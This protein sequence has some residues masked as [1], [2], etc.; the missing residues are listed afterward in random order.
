ML[1]R[2]EVKREIA[3]LRALVLGLAREGTALARF[4]AERR[5]RVT[6][7]D[8]K[9]AADLADRISALAGL[10]V[11]F[12]LGGHPETLLDETDIVFVSPGVPLEIPFLVE[13]R[14]RGVPLSSE[15]RL[16]TRLCPAIVVGVTGSS[17]KSTTTVLAGEMIRAAGWRTWIGGNIG[18]PLIGFLDEIGPEDAV[19]MELSSFQ[20]DLFGPWPARMHVG[21]R[22]GVLFDPDGWSPPVAAVLNVTPNHL[23][24]HPTMEDYVA[25]KRHILVHQ[26]PSD[27][28]VLNFD[29]P[30]TREMGSRATGAGQRV[31]WFSLDREVEE[32]ALLRDGQ[33][34]L[35]LAGIDVTV[36]R[37]DDLKLLGRHNLANALAACALAAGANIVQPRIT[38][39]VDLAQRGW[40]QGLTSFSGVEHRLELVRELNGVCW[41]NDSIATTPERTVAALRS[42]EAPIVLL[43]GGRDKH[44]PWAEMAA[45]TWHK[46]RHLILFGEA[47]DLIEREMQRARKPY[48]AGQ[49]ETMLHHAG[50]LSRA[51]ELAAQVARPGD[52]VLLSP[53]GTSFDAHRDFVARGEHF[54]RLVQELESD[55]V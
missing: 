31:L 42:F 7:T 1:E 20:L 14:R 4:L 55:D 22:T 40:R 35:R 54:R 39:W 12:A 30:V 11:S 41:Y 51:V 47:A 8:V 27:V 48:E 44:L 5:A 50:T 52:V 23:D 21:G 34:V 25:A 45:L 33:L 53:G 46:V 36:C 18:R 9:P 28:A 37:T 19:V 3:D 10:P 16:F 26:Q 13:A 15:T 2:A 43:A 38:P 29:D 17:G 32:G 49:A 24:R 6:V